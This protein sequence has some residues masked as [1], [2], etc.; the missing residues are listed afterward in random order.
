MKFLSEAIP[1]AYDA[2]RKDYF[3]AM[4]RLSKKFEK[5]HGVSRVYGSY[6]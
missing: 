1:K 5:K 3:E 6:R 2:I 4:N